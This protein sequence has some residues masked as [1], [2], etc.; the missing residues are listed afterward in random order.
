MTRNLPHLLTNRLILRFP[1]PSEAAAICTFQREN[2]PFLA[3]WEALKDTDY[4]TEPYWQTKIEQNIEDFYNGKS[5]C[6]TIYAQNNRTIMGMVNYSNIIRGAFHSCF[7]G[8]KIGEAYQQQ[9]YMTEALRGS[10]DY[11]FSV[12]NLHRISANYMPCNLASARVLEK[13]RFE[14]DGVAKNYLYINGKW[15]NHVLT[16]LL[17]EAWIH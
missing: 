1:D 10:L 13:C 8:F 6:L 16:S 7:L 17:N 14:M 11:V 15:E 2:E 9:G 5:C 3:Q 4:F 12:L